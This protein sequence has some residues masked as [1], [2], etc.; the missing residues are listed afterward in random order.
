MIT[1]RFVD[2][3]GNQFVKDL[4]SVLQETPHEDLQG[5]ADSLNA[6]IGNGKTDGDRYRISLAEDIFQWFA[7]T[8]KAYENQNPNP[9]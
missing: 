3:L 8:I 7:D 9:S 4:L 6:V 1:Q 5:I 2:G